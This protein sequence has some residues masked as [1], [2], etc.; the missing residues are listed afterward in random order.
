MKIRTDFVTNSSSSSFISYQVDAALLKKVLQ[1]NALSLKAK[2]KN[3]IR[4]RSSGNKLTL[5]YEDMN[6]APSLPQMLIAVLSAGKDYDNALE[7]DRLDKWSIEDDARVTA[8]TADCTAYKLQTQYDGSDESVAK[9]IFELYTETDL[10]RRIAESSDYSHGGGEEFIVAK[11]C[12]Y[13]SSG[14]HIITRNGKICEYYAHPYLGGFGYCGDEEAFISYSDGRVSLFD[15][16]MEYENQSVIW[17]DETASRTL[18]ELADEKVTCGLTQIEQLACRKLKQLL[19]PES[20]AR[21]LSGA[22]TDCSA[23]EKLCI[24]SDETELEDNSVAKTVK[25]IAPVGSPA[26]QY[27]QANGNAFADYAE[28]MLEF[29]LTDEDYDDFIISIMEGVSR[30]YSEEDDCYVYYVSGRCKRI[31]H[32]LFVPVIIFGSRTVVID[33]DTIQPNA[34]LYGFSGSTAEEY[35]KKHG[36]TFHVLDSTDFDPEA[37]PDNIRVENGTL[38]TK[39][40]VRLRLKGLT[41]KQLSEVPAGEKLVLAHEPDEMN[42][43]RLVFRTADTGEYRGIMS[44]RAGYTASYLMQKGY[45][46]F[47]HIITLEKGYFTADICWQEALTEQTKQQL[48]FYQLMYRRLKNAEGFITEYRDFVPFFSAALN[49]ANIDSKDSDLTVMSYYIAALFEPNNRLSYESSR[50]VRYYRAL[51]STFCY[52]DNDRYAIYGSPYA[53]SVDA[54]KQKITCYEYGE[55]TAL[56]PAEEEFARIYIDQYRKIYNLPPIFTNG[57]EQN[58]TV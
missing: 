35:A 18:A 5:K 27:A 53:F 36:L 17:D 51:L 1:N 2:D 46:R 9:L 33:E 42:D 6:S 8:G 7:Y 47:D 45:L 16:E 20:C 10:F 28:N 44:Y 43:L 4:T 31:D 38:F 13:E 14:E 56:S 29:V 54:A 25:I 48:H 57:G 39:G 50:C 15:R 34:A 55:Q 40:S 21:I 37:L 12:D 49:V 3:G 30:Y 41:D 24:P 19:I 22:L 23:L 26:H 32:E 58:G 52:N 11:F